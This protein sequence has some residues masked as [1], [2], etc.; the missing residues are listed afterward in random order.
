MAPKTPAH[1]SSVGPLLLFFIIIIIIAQ[2]LDAAATLCAPLPLISRFFYEQ[3]S[4]QPFLRSWSGA[5]SPSRRCSLS[6]P[7]LDQTEYLP[8][9]RPVALVLLLSFSNLIVSLTITDSKHGPL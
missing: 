2:G 1:Q 4:I 6:D 5:L 3:F 7:G 8:L 9:F